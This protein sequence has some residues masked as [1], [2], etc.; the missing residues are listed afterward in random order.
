MYP[1]VPQEI[2][3]QNYERKKTKLHMISRNDRKYKYILLHITH[4]FRYELNDLDSLTCPK[5]DTF[6][7]S[8]LILAIQNGHD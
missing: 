3:L 7:S 5:C 6:V 8:L 2:I 1:F 4:Y